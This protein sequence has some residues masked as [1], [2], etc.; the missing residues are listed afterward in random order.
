MSNNPFTW[1]E[2][3]ATPEAITALLEGSP[4]KTTAGLGTNHDNSSDIAQSGAYAKIQAAV[5]K[6]NE[7]GRAIT[8]DIQEY[9]RPASG[10]PTGTF[11]IIFT[12]ETPRQLQQ[13]KAA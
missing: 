9:L 8:C 4:N 5:T 12:E 3:Y 1:L 13:E 7:Q 11:M 2:T 10:K 6:L